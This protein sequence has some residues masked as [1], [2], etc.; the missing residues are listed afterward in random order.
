M[1][2]VYLEEGV[3]LVSDNETSRV[4]SAISDLVAEVPADL[5]P[6]AKSLAA[7]IEFMAETMDALKA[8]V[9]ENGPVEEFVNGRQR[10][11]RENPAMKSYNVTVRRFAD[12]CKQLIALLPTDKDRAAAAEDAIREFCGM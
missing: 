12:T 5:Q 3:A 11:R 8:D 10:M 7:E 1:R 4:L 9:R 2:G 6:M